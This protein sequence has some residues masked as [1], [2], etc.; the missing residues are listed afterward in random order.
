MTTKKT[1]VKKPEPKKDARVLYTIRL[2][3][4]VI[5]QIEKIAAKKQVTHAEV[6]RQYLTAGCA[7]AR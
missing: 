2:E 4:S 6:A 7:R 3:P 5:A 1:A